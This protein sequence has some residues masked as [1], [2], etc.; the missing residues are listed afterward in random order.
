MGWYI[1]SSFS[2]SKSLNG[3]TINISGKDKMCLL[4]GEMGGTFTALTNDLSKIEIWD[5]VI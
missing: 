1:I 3:Y 2:Y 5:E 4:N